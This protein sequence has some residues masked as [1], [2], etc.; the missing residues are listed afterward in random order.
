[1]TDL[2]DVQGLVFSG[3]AAQPLARYFF[4]RFGSG[5]ARGFLGEIL[6]RVSSAALEERDEPRRLNVALSVSGLRALG[7]DES[8][9]ATFPRELRQGMAHPE[10][11]RALGDIGLDA[12]E[13]WQLGRPDLGGVDGVV[14]AYASTE[15]ELDEESELIEAALE[16]HQVLAEAEDAYLPPDGREHFGFADARTNP[17][18][19]RFSLK[20][21]DNPWDPRIPLGELLLGHRNARGVRTARPSARAKRNTRELALPIEGGRLVDLGKNGSYLALRKL[22]QDVPGFFRFVREQAKHAYPGDPDPAGH[23]AA[24]IVGRWPNGASLVLSPDAEPADASVSNRF[25]YR[26]HDELGR[27]CPFG[28]HARRANPRDQLGDDPRESLRRMRSHRLVRRGRLYGPRYDENTPSDE[29]R[30]L[31]FMALCASLSSQFEFVQESLL[32]NT[33]APG[34]YRERDPLVGRG[35]GDAASV[36]GADRRR[37]EP[38]TI[39]GAPYARQVSIRRFVRVR[40]GAY[41]F[42]PSL[43]ALAYLA[44]P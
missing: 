4:L 3:Y 25:G 14:F 42:L 33:Q 15:D 39:P 31:F 34:V 23:L 16:R 11:S 9:I 36:D 44:E 7:L 38:F 30:G 2:N 40:G 35:D 27:R 41:L 13:H 8:A 22:E 18:L 37:T 10:R 32:E 28:A 19:A 6:N 24:A 5:D 1:V 17:R 26:E 12:P 20:P 29:P 43:R 21:D